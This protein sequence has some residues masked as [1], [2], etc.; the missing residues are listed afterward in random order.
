MAQ[1]DA[2]HP[3]EPEV[4]EDPEK[5]ALDKAA[6]FNAFGGTDSAQLAVKEEADS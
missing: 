3:E 6:P 2:W 1:Q 4:P 5:T